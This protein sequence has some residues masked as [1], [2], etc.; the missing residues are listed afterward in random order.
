MSSCVLENMTDDSYE[1][2]KQFATR[3]FSAVNQMMKFMDNLAEVS[4]STDMLFDLKVK[5]CLTDNEVKKKI[6]KTIAN[7]LLIYMICK[8]VGD[9]CENSAPSKHDNLSKNNGNMSMFKNYELID[10][11]D[12]AV[13]FVIMAGNIFMIFD[14]YPAPSPTTII[15]LL[16]TTQ[17]NC[18]TNRCS[19][20][21]RYII[22]KIA[23]IKCLT[24]LCVRCY[25]EKS[26]NTFVDNGSY[27]GAVTCNKCKYMTIP[28]IMPAITLP[29]HFN[30][31]V[32]LLIRIY[33]N[34]DIEKPDVQYLCDKMKK[35]KMTAGY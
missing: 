5:S 19:C 24:L 28:H 25:F 2:L 4:R 21:N 26:I 30:I 18:P 7:N 32:G 10:N 23:C 16:R 33:V 14:Q 6:K 35:I 31:T 17:P 13:Q 34:H 27:N 11:A 20:C 8:N 22:P 15:K 9:L 1:K 12:H 29:D 3:D